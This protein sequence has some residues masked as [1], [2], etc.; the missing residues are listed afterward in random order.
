[1][2]GLL[3]VVG[4]TYADDA[5]AQIFKFKKKDGTIVY[6][7]SLA[8]LPP[9]RRAYYNKKLQEREEKKQEQ[10]RRLGKEEYE[11]RE[12]E[13]QLA[14]LKEKQM[15]EEER[16]RRVAALNRV[17]SEMRQKVAKREAH[18]KEWQEKMA[19]AKKEVQRLLGE[20]NETQEK[21]K[22]L[23]TKASFSLLPGQAQEME[24]LRQKLPE[25]EAQLDAAIE[26]LEFELPEQA[27][28]AGIPPGWLR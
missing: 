8:Q 7:D 9:K 26:H 19:K 3:V 28:K 13:K 12:K 15:D 5:E 17:L 16:Q 23:A 14:A 21:Y 22:N 20:F 2:L 1:M 10:I 27:R 6:T 18:K 24:K 25:L 4:L 11:R